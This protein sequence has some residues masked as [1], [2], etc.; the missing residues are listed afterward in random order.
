VAL[1]CQDQNGDYLQKGDNVRISFSITNVYWDAS[2]MG[3]KEP[4]ADLILIDGHLGSSNGKSARLKGVPTRILD[5][6][7]NAQGPK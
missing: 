3:V 4:F 1:P 5:K 2:D 6:I 7:G